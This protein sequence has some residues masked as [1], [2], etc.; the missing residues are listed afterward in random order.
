M[1]RERR[2]RLRR[3]L[4]K[5]NAFSLLCV[6]IP[7]GCVT[8][9]NLLFVTVLDRFCFMQYNFMLTSCSVLSSQ[10]SSAFFAIPIDPN[11]PTMLV[12]THISAPGACV[13][14]ALSAEHYTANAALIHK[15]RQAIYIFLAIGTFATNAESLAY[16]PFARGRGAV[17]IYVQANIQTTVCIKP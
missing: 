9:I 11:E 14:V 3:V 13:T 5:A 8:I 2:R 6:S 17:L 16:A 15:L 10:R 7:F 1:G 4:S 12:A